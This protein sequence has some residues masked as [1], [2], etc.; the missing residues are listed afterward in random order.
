MEE[1]LVKTGFDVPAPEFVNLEFS[2]VD[3]NGVSG[4]DAVD[5]VPRIQISPNAMV[6]TATILLGLMLLVS[7]VEG[8]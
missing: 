1:T 7:W 6:W 3:D 8:A 4:S 2:S 5:V